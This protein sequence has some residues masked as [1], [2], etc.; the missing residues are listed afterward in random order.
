MYTDMH[1]RIHRDVHVSHMS[2][3]PAWAHGH[4][5]HTHNINWGAG[6]VLFPHGEHTLS[7][8]HRTLKPPQRFPGEVISAVKG[9]VVL[10]MV[11]KTWRLVTH[12]LPDPEMPTVFQRQ[13]AG[14]GWR[15]ELD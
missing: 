10:N 4:K 6:E 11:Q 14:W 1:V 2:Y 5:N 3:V 9:T 8:E 15:H 12:L 13:L 7:P